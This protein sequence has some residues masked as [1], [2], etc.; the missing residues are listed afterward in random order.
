MICR[1]ENVKCDNKAIHELIQ[2]SE[3]DMR[4]AIIYL[5]SAYRLKGEDTVEA[6]DITEIAGEI[7]AEGHAAAQIINQVH[8]RIVEM[9]EL[10]DH[11]KSAI[12]EKLAFN[13]RVCGHQLAV[14][15]VYRNKERVLNSYHSAVKASLPVAAP[16]PRP[17]LK[18]KLAVCLSAT[19]GRQQH[20]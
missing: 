6:K 16:G 7:I 1:E 8:D 2:I 19:R 4:K 13:L 17:A 10:N 11:Q 18:P 3:G 14:Q 15:Q 12:T 5:Q 9:I 20:L